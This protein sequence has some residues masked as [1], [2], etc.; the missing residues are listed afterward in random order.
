[1]GPWKPWVSFYF[2]FGFCHHLVLFSQIRG[3]RS[4][5]RETFDFLLTPDVSPKKKTWLLCPLVFGLR[6]IRSVIS[7]GFLLVWLASL[8][9]RAVT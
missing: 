4:S 5:K 1:M 6:A 7:P 3:R 2:V 8:W 9:S